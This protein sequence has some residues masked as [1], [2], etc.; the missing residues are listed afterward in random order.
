MTPDEF[1]QRIN[2]GARGTMI[3]SHGTRFLA[4]ARRLVAA[5]TATRLRPRPA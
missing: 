1:A 3:E 4:A 5:L 2:E